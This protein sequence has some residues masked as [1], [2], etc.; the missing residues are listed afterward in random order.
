VTIPPPPTP[1][2]GAGYFFAYD[3]A[4]AGS[5][6]IEGEV[7]NYGPVGAGSFTLGFYLSGDTA[8]STADTLLG[9]LSVSGLAAGAT[10]EFSEYVTAPASVPG[11]AYYLGVVIDHANAVA[12]SNEANNAAL[13]W[14]PVTVPETPPGIAWERMLGGTA[15][16]EAH[17]V[18]QTAD[19]GYVLLGCSMSSASGNVTD[20]TNG[21]SYNGD[22]WLVKTN[23]AG[24]VQWQNLLGGSREEDGHSVQQTADGGYI[25]F[26]STN[27]GMTGDV[28]DTNRGSNFNDYW[29][30]KLNPAGAKQWDRVL[31]GPG[32]DD[33]RCVQQTLDGGY[34]LVGDSSSNT[35]GD[36][37][38]T[39]H[40]D[41]D[42]WV[43]KV[44]ATG[45]IQWQNL[46]G[47]SSTD[48]GYSVR[49]RPSGPSR[50]SQAMPPCLV[51][52][53]R[54]SSALSREPSKA[55]TTRS[56]RSPS[57]CASHRNQGSRESGSGIAP[58]RNMPR[59]TS[60]Y[61]SWSVPAQPR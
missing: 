13:D 41:E 57:A 45:V 32:P 19:G 27:S 22:F 61:S 3:A 59:A 52:R 14:D 30:V 33:G 48:R 42:I 29:L 11:G 6:W 37:N 53:A 58:R 39:R 60:S 51:V 35:G 23:A 24:T 1:D 36:V 31:G 16:D 43:V 21:G 4:P 9:T 49:G 40:G 28:S 12:E 5:F 18:Q 2:L 56:T 20:T 8:I 54:L 50:C 10:E 44:N 34:I 25:A 46:I 38:D 7:G 55:P 17:S 15:R 47:G 26:G